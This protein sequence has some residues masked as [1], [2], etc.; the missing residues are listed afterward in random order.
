MAVEED[1]ALRDDAP[2]AE[3][4]DEEVVVPLEPSFC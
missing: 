2:V 3:E 1:E 4:A